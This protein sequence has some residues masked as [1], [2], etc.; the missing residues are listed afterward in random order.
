MEYK[1]ELERAFLLCTEKM[2]PE[3]V[4]LI[5]KMFDEFQSDSL[6]VV[7][8]VFDNYTRMLQDPYLQYTTKPQDVAAQALLTGIFISAGLSHS[9]EFKERILKFAQSH[10]PDTT[11]ILTF[12]E[13]RRKRAL[14]ISKGAF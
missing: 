7:T 6:R 12:E 3:R 13:V 5:S 11:K 14:G 1:A 2:N 10:L 4:K 8:Q 9:P